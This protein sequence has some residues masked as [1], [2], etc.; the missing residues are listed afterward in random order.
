[1]AGHRLDQL[2]ELL[3]PLE[4]EIMQII[5]QAPGPILVRQVRD[6]I[7]AQRTV[8]HTTIMSTM[9]RLAEKGIFVREGAGRTYDGR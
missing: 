1:M 4:S 3:G 9:C 7:A 6:I 2:P 8:A 5:W